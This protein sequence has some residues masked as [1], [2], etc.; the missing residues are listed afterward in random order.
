MWRVLHASA[1]HWRWWD[2]ECVVYHS[3]SGD[4]HRLNALAGRAL[5]K[6]A[7]EPMSADM[8]AERLSKT[9][10]GSTEGPDHPALTV[11]LSRTIL[12]ELLSRLN[13]LGLIES[14]DVHDSVVVP[15]RPR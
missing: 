5:E 8:L 15:A 9:P 4:T 3:L 12:D 2:G 6:L 1:L 14:D 10:G 13:A 11:P 7:A